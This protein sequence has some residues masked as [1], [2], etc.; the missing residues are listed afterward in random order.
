MM[1][2]SGVAAYQPPD[3]P[4]FNLGGI[5]LIDLQTN[6]PLHQVPV[7]L[8]TEDGLAMTQNP[9]FVE[10]FGDGLRFY[11]MPEDND[12]RLFIYDVEA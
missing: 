1:L 2:C 5:D 6:A 7:S 12:S 11:F 4:E 9:F 8:W 3:A 10:E